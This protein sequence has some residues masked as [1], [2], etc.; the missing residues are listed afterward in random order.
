MKDGMLGILAKLSEVKDAVT[1]QYLTG[2]VT[3]FTS[4]PANG[5]RWKKDERPE[6]AEIRYI[7][8]YKDAVQLCAGKDSEQIA[9]IVW[10]PRKEFMELVN[11][12]SA[13]DASQAA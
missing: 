13:A 10:V 3:G 6:R 12:E 7:G 4:L 2:F 1:F 8:E 5:K 11:S 9:F